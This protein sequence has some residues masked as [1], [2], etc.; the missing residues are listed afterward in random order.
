MSDNITMLRKI[1]KECQAGK[2]GGK[3]IDLF[4][5]SAII[6]V[7]DKINPDNRKRFL[8]IIE[9]DIYLAAKTAFKII[10]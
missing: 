5:A 4:S 3:P 7:Y 6:G 9:K 1:V 2:V 10:K 8:E